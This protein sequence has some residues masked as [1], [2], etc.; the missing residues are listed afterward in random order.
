[1][2]VIRYECL[3]PEIPGFGTGTLDLGIRSCSVVTF[4]ETALIAKPEDL[5][6]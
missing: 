3:R 1:M 4:A 2:K 5:G 6:P